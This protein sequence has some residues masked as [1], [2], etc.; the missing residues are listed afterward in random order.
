MSRPSQSANKENV[1]MDM[2]MQSSDDETDQREPQSLEEK[3]R[4]RSEYRRL[5]ADTEANKQDLVKPDSDG[6]MNTL[7][8]ANKLFATVT[9]TQEGTLD[10]KLLVQVA[11]LG[12]KKAQNMRFDA[13]CFDIDDF[14]RKAKGMMA[15]GPVNVAEDEDEERQGDRSL[16]WF[17]LGNVAAKYLLRVPTLDFLLGP[18][19]VEPKV[20]QEGRKIARLVK[21]KNDLRKPQEL[22]K[23]DFQKE[24]NETSSAVFQVARHLAAH[25][26]INFFKFIINPESFGQTVENMFHL[27]FLIKEGKAKIEIDEDGDPIVERVHVEDGQEDPDAVKRQLI[28]ELDY[29]TYE[30]S[31]TYENRSFPLEKKPSHK[32]TGNGTD[33]KGI[34]DI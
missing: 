4:I 15:V 8:E 18:L 21:D 26:P 11:E 13:N 24:K 25:G 12:S 34:N 22:T 29:Q 31:T 20:R 9:T 28:M 1:A 14:V 10:S 23:D 16:D 2:D 32:T 30:K 19:A 7:Y 17:A 33:S 3:R 5:L 6:L 27:A